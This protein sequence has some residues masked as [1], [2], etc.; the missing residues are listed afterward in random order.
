MVGMHWIIEKYYATRRENWMIGMYWVFERYVTREDI[1][2]RFRDI[3]TV[4]LDM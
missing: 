2:S 3:I 1:D 4:I